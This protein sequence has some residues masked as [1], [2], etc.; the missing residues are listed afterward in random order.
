[1][2]GGLVAG[3]LA[4]TTAFADA[5]LAVAGA[6]VEL[7]EICPTAPEAVRDMDVGPAPPPGGSVLLDRERVLAQ[8]RAAGVD[9]KSVALPKLLRIVSSSRRWSPPE[10]AEF[11]RGAVEAALPRGVSLTHLDVR[12]PLIAAPGANAGPRRSA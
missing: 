3:L 7:G 12:V 6:R 5:P 11:V 4:A 8:L 10:L 2:L 9:P 1:M